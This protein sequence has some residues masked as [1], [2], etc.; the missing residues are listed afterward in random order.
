MLIKLKL[1][2]LHKVDRCALVSPHLDSLIDE[3][4]KRQN[5]IVIITIQFYQIDQSNFEKKKI[6]ST[7]IEK[8]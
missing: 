8:N 4:C 7:S 5:Y 3:T 2:N 1:L 6:T